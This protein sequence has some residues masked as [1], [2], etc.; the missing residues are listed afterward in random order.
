MISLHRLRKLFAALAL[1]ASLIGSATA[2]LFTEIPDAGQTIG[3]ANNAAVVSPLFGIRGTLSNEPSAGPDLVDMFR[4]SIPTGA[5]FFAN[6]GPG[7]DPAL[8]ADPVLFLFNALGVGVAMDDESGGFGQASLST[9][10]LTGGIYFLAIAFAGLE[11][12]DSLGNP[13]FDTFGSGGLLSALALASWFGSPFSLDPSIEGR[14]AIATYYVPLPGT[15]LL[16]L[17][18]LAALRTTRKSRS[19]RA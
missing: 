1:G 8:I 4:V 10:V 6:T 16:V 19:R 17:V 14:Y 9:G 12:L 18:G 5:R 15:L 2:A 11:P 3:T 7:T 13:I